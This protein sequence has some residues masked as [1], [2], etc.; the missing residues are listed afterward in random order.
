MAATYG[1]PAALRLPRAPLDALL[2]QTL[3]HRADG[4]ARHE[5]LLAHAPLVLQPQGTGLVALAGPVST[6]P[7]RLLASPRAA[8]P[9]APA[10]DGLVLLALAPAGSPQP[11]GDAGW[12][13]WLL[14]HAPGSGWPRRR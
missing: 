12:E 13:A 4:G 3:T 8:E 11:Q 14:Q 6:Q 5:L 7:L 9:A 10:S 1:V 2:R